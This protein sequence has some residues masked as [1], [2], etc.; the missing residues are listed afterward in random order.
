MNDYENKLKKFI[1][2]NNIRAEHLVFEQS[3]HSVADAAA[4]VGTSEDAFIK[5]VIFISGNRT[6]VGIVTGDTR[7]SSSRL[8][9]HL[10]TELVIAS[11][12]HVLEATGYPVGG[13]PPFGY[14]AIFYIDPKVMEKE[15]VYG[16]GGSSRA[17]TKVA[18]NEIM[19]ITNAEVKRVRK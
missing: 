13:V 16:G 8:K 6:I 14:D 3:C 19:R 10:G 9:K 7:A 12:E 18:P 11:P 1:S 5:S 2:K 15:E 17:L 4:A